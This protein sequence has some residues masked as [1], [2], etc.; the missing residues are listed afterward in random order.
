[1]AEHAYESTLAAYA[2]R[3]A[4]SRGRVHPEPE[5]KHRNPYQRDRDRIIHST[6]FRRL[7]Y[8]TRP[9]SSSIMRAITTAPG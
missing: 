2:C 8:K 9:R 5:A 7:E 4:C 3:T 1:L 6:A